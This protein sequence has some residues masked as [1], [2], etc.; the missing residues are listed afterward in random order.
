MCEQESPGK[1]AMKPQNRRICR[2]REDRAVVN[3]TNRPGKVISP[4]RRGGGGGG[5]GREHEED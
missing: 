3:P 5:G 4:E 1:G 2:G